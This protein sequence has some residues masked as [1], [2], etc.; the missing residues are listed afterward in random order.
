MLEKAS[1]GRRSWELNKDQRCHVQRKPER[2]CAHHQGCKAGRRASAAPIRR[3]QCQGD[4]DRARR[5]GARCRWKGEKAAKID[6]SVEED[7]FQ[8]VLID[9]NCCEYS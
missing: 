3:R 5:S 8:V 9:K 6:A 1:T 4:G 2:S 7:Y